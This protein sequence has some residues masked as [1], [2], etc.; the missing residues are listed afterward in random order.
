MNAPG[1]GPGR[2]STADIVAVAF[3]VALMAALAIQPM[4][5]TRQPDRQSEF[6]WE[7]FSKAAPREEFVIQF[8]DRTEIGTPAQVLEPARANLDYTTVLPEWLCSQHPG[9]SSVVTRRNGEQIG[10]LDCG[11]R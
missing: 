7:M 4:F 9:A 6:V 2:R 3:V 5:P 8:D 11:S 1:N 10:L